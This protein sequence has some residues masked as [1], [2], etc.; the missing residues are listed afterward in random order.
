MQTIVEFLAILVVWAAGAAFAQFGVEVDL[1]RPPATQ[2]RVVERTAIAEARPAAG[3]CPDAAK[4][5]LQ[6][7]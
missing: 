7:V 1:S 3:E 5:R 2:E 4:A 6:P